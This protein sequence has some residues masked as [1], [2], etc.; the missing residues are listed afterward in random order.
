MENKKKRERKMSKIVILGAGHVGVLC[1]MNL[2]YCGICREIVL[3]DVE[4]E[5]AEAQA[6]DVA[7]ATAFLPRQTV[8][9]AGEYSDLDD[10]DILVNAVGIS[11]R[12]GQ[13]RLDMLD[14]SVD[15]MDEVI[16]NMKQT[17]FQGIIISISN[18]CDVIAQYFRVQYGY[19]AEKI[20]GTGTSLDTARLRRTISELAGVDMKSVTCYALGEHGD[21]SM[22]PM[23]QVRIGGEKLL[24]L[25]KENPDRFGN[26]TRE[27][28]EDRTHQIGMEIVIG[29]G[30]TEFGIGAAVADLCKAVLYDEHRVL[31]VSTV[32]NGEYHQTDLMIG[33]PAL[34]GRNG[35]EMILELPLTAEEQAALNHSCDVVREYNEKARK[36]H[37]YNLYK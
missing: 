36:R 33:V 9:R 10:A 11:R 29:K 18:P 37:E 15:I 5:K 6:K 20:F 32:L 8:I 28:L 30:S 7:D 3:I 13:T 31:P 21:S 27:L 17:K 35:V 16:K 2:A 4:K 23:S 25:Q 34:I 19:P 14:F 24:K 12:P 26:I 1:A 22:V